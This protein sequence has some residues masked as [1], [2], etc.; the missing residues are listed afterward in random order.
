M[1]EVRDATPSDESAFLRLWQ[2][3]IDGY[4]LLMG[5]VGMGALAE[6]RVTMTEASKAL[7]GAKVPVEPG[8]GDFLRLWV[9]VIDTPTVGPNPPG[10]PGFPRAV[11]TP[12]PRCPRRSRGGENP[13]LLKEKQ[14][15]ANGRLGVRTRSARPGAPGSWLIATS[16]ALSSDT[17]MTASVACTCPTPPIDSTRFKPS[18]SSTTRTR[19]RCDSAFLLRPRVI[20]STTWM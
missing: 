7:M 10:P 17:P 5:A 15:Q 13:V 14:A 11:G 18:E 20:R 8:E 3:F 2:G 12:G 19:T 4:G 9:G 16:C 1:V 6:V